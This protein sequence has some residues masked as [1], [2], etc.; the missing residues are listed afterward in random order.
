MDAAEP[1]DRRHSA[2][3]AW[4]LAAIVVTALGVRL[5]GLDRH[6]LTHEEVYVPR[7]AMPDY[8]SAP[9]PRAT[10]A[11]TVRGTLYHDNHPPAYYAAMWLWTGVAG[12]DLFALRFPSAL[13]GAAAAVL[14]FG[15]VRRRDGWA[16]ALTAAALL[17]LHGHHVLW[18]QRARM[19]VFLAALALLSLLLLESLA[20]DYRRGRAAAYVGV[21]AVGLWTEY[22][23]WPFFLVQVLWESFR[24]SEESRLPATV[25][26]QILAVVAAAPVLVFLQTHLAL[27]RTGYLSRAGVGDHLGGFLL[28]QWLVR[29]PP[30]GEVFG[31]LASVA[32]LVLLAA[33]VIF[34]LAGIASPAASEGPEPVPAPKPSWALRAAAVGVPTFFSIWLIGSGERN[35][36]AYVALFLPTGM[37]LLLPLAERAW[38][39]VSRCLRAARANAFIRRSVD[40]AAGVH[41]MAPLFL[42]LGASL[43]VPSVASRSLLFLTPF[44]LWLMARGLARVLPGVGARAVVTVLLLL[45]CGYSVFQYTRPGIDGRDYQALAESMRPAL[46]TDDVILIRDAWYAQPMHY[47][48][49]P[50]RFR[51][52]DFAEHFAGGPGDRVWVV[53]LDGRDKEAWESRA[54]PLAD[55]VP[56]RRVGT[57]RAYAVLF[58][59]VVPPTDG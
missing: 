11:E 31:P 55:H 45:G 17:A 14:I 16:T 32:I 22:S 51:T 59:P 21:V 52:G 13:A 30:A 9:P 49:P 35:V 34:L 6:T 53:I 3:V 19:W 23:F 28:F 5:W 29:S 2:R 56:R 12:T 24:R 50:D 38:S 41:A 46:A 1:G 57:D 20:R 27:D 18:S 43:I 48:F 40:D 15:L 36:S 42:L 44:A 39:F 4:C 26:L 33:G 10:L 58:E 37:L 25:E 7:L 8:V 47:Y 54:H